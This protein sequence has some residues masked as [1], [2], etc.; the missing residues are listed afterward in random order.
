MKGTGAN[1]VEVARHVLTVLTPLYKTKIVYIYKHSDETISSAPT[2]ISY[3]FSTSTL[4][5]PSG[6]SVSPSGLTGPIWV[7]SGF[8][9]EESPNN[10]SW[11]LP[12]IYLTHELAS[13]ED[14]HLTKEIA[15]YKAVKSTSSAPNTPTGGSYSFSSGTFQTPSDWATEP[16]AAV[17]SYKSSASTGD[18]DNYKIWK[19]YNSYQC[20]ASVDTPTVYGTVTDTGWTIPVVYL[21]I[22][23]ILNDADD[24][25]NETFTTALNNAASD[26][27]DAAQLV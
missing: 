16:N 10:I 7:S 4:T 14:K 9:S 27:R 18:E 23:G 2:G 5:P 8:V 13:V 22:D 26:L 3:D 25:A 6:W 11:N 15:V 20:T 12:S 1:A 19:S 21:D 17:L 24:R